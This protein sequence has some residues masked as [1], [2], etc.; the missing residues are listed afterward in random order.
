M[1]KCVI[2][3][4]DGTLLNTLED[5]YDS[6]N[7]ALNKFGY[8]RRTIDEIK[9]FIGNGVKLLIERAIPNG[10]NDPNVDDCLKTFKTHYKINMYNKTA[11]YP[12]VIELL[13]I[14]KSRNIK[15]AVVSNKFDLAVRELCEKYF[16]N[17]ID[18]IV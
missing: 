11:P 18:V 2:F 12:D 15:V 16:P 6:T 14:L 3:D 7:Y 4:L 13:K 10:K 9:A 17:L 8:P 1:I 5:L